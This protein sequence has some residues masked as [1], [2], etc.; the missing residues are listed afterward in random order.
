M[1]NL[2]E[3]AIMIN[4]LNKEF[5]E[6][7]N[8]KESFKKEN[9]EMII[10]I[11]NMLFIHNVDSV[12]TENTWYNNDELEE[13]EIKRVK[14]M[15]DIIKGLKNKDILKWLEKFYIKDKDIQE[16]ILNKLNEITTNNIVN[17]LYEHSIETHYIEY[18]INQMYDIIRGLKNHESYDMIYWFQRHNIEDKEFQKKILDELLKEIKSISIADE[19]YAFSSDKSNLDDK[20]NNFSNKTLYLREFDTPDK[21]LE[22]CTR[23]ILPNPYWEDFIDSEYSYKEYFDGLICPKSMSSIKTC[24]CKTCVYINNKIISLKE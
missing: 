18:E 19:N 13:I 20:M 5:E 14:Q 9:E 8:E 15:Y 1:E 17:I 12:D 4:K 21:K 16:K 24:S 22:F 3:C 2:P 10:S 11:T 6:L 23:L 7:Y